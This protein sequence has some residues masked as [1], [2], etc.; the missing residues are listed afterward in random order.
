MAPM[1]QYHQGLASVSGFGCWG[2]V[3]GKSLA[4]SFISSEGSPIFDRSGDHVPSR[5]QKDTS[6]NPK[7]CRHPSRNLPLTAS[8]P[9]V[10]S[11]CNVAERPE[12]RLLHRTDLRD[13]RAEGAV[14]YR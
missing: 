3:T 14:C 12:P 2:L 10:A 1:P 8:I 4:A 6:E 7:R 13:L 5:V 9:L 11:A